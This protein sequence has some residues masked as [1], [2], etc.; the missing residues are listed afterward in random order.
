MTNV[1][2]NLIKAAGTNNSTNARTDNLAMDPERF[3]K[4]VKNAKFTKSAMC[5]K[6][7]D[8]DGGGLPESAR[9]MRTLRVKRRVMRLTRRVIRVKHDSYLIHRLH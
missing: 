6:D 9:P 8:Y 7:P 1:L 2:E 3:F 5:H 4:D